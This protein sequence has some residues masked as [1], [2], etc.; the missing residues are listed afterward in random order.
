MKNFL[1]LLPIIFIVS[2]CQINL[3]AKTLPPKPVACTM[4]AKF[5][6][7][8]SAVGRTGP[9]CEFAACPSVTPTT[10]PPVP[11]PEPIGKSGITGVSLIGPVCPVERIPPDPA[12]A[13]R[14]YPAL[15]IV[16]SADGTKEITR[17]NTDQNGKFKIG[18]PP[19]NYLLEPQGNN[20]YPRG[21]AQTVLV[22]AGVFTSVNV[23][24]D[25]GIR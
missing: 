13:P 20:V 4:E 19:G 5:C 8:G 15:V 22:K 10:T 12:C 24:F 9:N 16:K 25:S 7:D 18:L 6:P 23:N 3:P 21:I 14:P 1:Y 11:S 2:G 17:F